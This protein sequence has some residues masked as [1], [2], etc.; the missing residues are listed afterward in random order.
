MSLLG[1]LVANGHSICSTSNGKH[2]YIVKQ[3]KKSNSLTH[4]SYSVDNHF[5]HSKLL[6]IRLNVHPRL[7]L[8]PF[9]VYVDQYTVW[10]PYV[11]YGIVLDQDLTLFGGESCDRE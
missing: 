10:F 1:Q 5:V 7:V 3:E 8:I 11:S 2:S 4:M 9:H 6:S